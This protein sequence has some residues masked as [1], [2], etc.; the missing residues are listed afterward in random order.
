L[1]DPFS[2]PRA[3]REGD[4][5]VARATVNLLE[6]A[7]QA[8]VPLW[9]LGPSLVQGFFRFARWLPNRVSGIDKSQ[10][11]G[12]YLLLGSGTGALKMSKEDAAYKDRPVGNQRCGNCSSA[13]KHLVSGDLICSQVEGKVVAKGWCRIWNQERL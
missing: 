8:G 13:Y 9:R 12:L 1:S 7:V 6:E 10:V 11:P 4:P 3:G 5:R 2:Y